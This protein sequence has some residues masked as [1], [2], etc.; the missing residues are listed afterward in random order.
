MLRLVVADADAVAVV[1]V[2]R[3]ALRTKGERLVLFEM[4]VRIDDMFFL[5]SMTG[6]D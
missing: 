1:L 3:H 6:F 5:T 4:S 2:V